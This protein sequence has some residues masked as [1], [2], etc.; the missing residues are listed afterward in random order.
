[1]ADI[2]WDDL[3]D[4]AE[5]SDYAP[6]PQSDY[7]VKI[8]DTEATKSS[9]DKP[10][11]K[12]TA[13]VLNGPHAGRKLFTQQ[14][15]TMDSPDALNMFFRQMAAAGLTGEF[16]KTKPSNERIAEAL[17]GRQFR[18]KVTIREWQG[19]PRN[20]IKQWNP[21]GAGGGAPGGPPPPPATGAAP[22]GPPPP[23]SSGA[24][25]TPPPPGP[26]S[27]SA[28]PP[29]AAPAAPPQP[30]A[31]QDAPAAQAPAQ[32]PPQSAPETNG[33][34]APPAQE[35]QP[36]AAPAGGGAD[37]WVVEERKTGST[38]PPPF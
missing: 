23:P 19:V 5:G 38:E 28:P 26:P 13:E 24:T 2:P 18:A 16:F 21:I 34:A 8:V 3:M 7:D 20:N 1:M 25:S 27:S 31:Q 17:L 10:M 37:P 15:L 30:P 29:P 6:I 35:L 14:T 4:A 22:G 11:W 12:I 33:A 32:A 36:A 9:T